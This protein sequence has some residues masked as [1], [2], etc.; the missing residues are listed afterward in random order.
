MGSSH[1]DPKNPYCM[2]QDIY[3]M[4]CIQE[5]V[6]IIYGDILLVENYVRKLVL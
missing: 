4:K 1:L 2:Q 5:K 6:N 3:K